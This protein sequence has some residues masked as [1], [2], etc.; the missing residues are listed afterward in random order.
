MALKVT[1]NRAQA[2]GRSLFIQTLSSLLPPIYLPLS[3]AMDA[4]ALAPLIEALTG[5]STALRIAAFFLVWMLVWLPIAIPLSIVLKWRPPQPLSVGQK[6]SLVLSL[7]SFAPLLLW[8]IA[9]L[10]GVPFSS[11]GIVGGA[12]TWGGLAVGV[13]L[14]A[15][16]VWV[17]FS[18]E[19]WLG[20]STWEPVPWGKLP[21][22]LLPTFMLALAISGVEELVFRGFL[23]NQLQSG[24]SF[25]FAAVGS[26]L[27]FAGLHLVWEGKKVIPQLPG[28]WLM[29]MVLVLA[30][31]VDNGNLALPCGLHAGW[32]WAMA[33]LDAAQLIRQSDRAPVW[34]VGAAGQPLAG[35]LGLLLLLGTGGLL[36][37]V[38][39]AV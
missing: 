35:L 39:R 15:A 30:R 10:Q 36:W 37:G 7:Y 18:L 33:S 38:S 9:R 19:R 3:T 11:Y 26:S 27:I 29:G 17:L 2:A 1:G 24:T 8:A 32:I 6:L 4:Q 13:L 28:L 25:W 21:A 23:L 20:W 5:T 34:I 22:I 16:G 12:S 31:W 14:A